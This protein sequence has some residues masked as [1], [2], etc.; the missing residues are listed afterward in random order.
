MDTQR[1]VMRSGMPK[2]ALPST[3][4]WDAFKADAQRFRRTRIQA[5][6]TAA[7]IVANVIPIQS[8]SVLNRN[9]ARRFHISSA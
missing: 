1:P 7:P 6:A 8:K 5:L 2:K 3:A 9:V 4:R